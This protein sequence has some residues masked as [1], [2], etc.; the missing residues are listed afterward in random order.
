MVDGIKIKADTFYTL[1]NGKF[2]EVKDKEE[3]ESK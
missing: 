2:V 1:I 3:G